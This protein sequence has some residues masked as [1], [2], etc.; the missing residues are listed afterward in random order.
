MR[1]RSI[2]VWVAIGLVGLALAAGVSYAATQLS[3]QRIGLSAE[4]PSAGEQLAPPTATA[5]ARTTTAPPARTT[6]SGGDRGADDRGGSGG[7]EERGEGGG[8]GSGD[9]DD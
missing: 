4:P 8:S 9:W 5:P 2:L 6:P 1:T 3:S 7:P